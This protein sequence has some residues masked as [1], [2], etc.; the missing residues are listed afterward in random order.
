[1]TLEP[2]IAT[3]GRK[4][5]TK[6]AQ[7]GSSTTTTAT[8]RKAAPATNEE[9]PAPELK[10]NLLN[11]VLRN[12]SDLGFDAMMLNGFGTPPPHGGNLTPITMN[13]LMPSGASQGDFSEVELNGFQSDLTQVDE[14]DYADAQYSIWKQVT[15]QARA[16][17]AGDRN[18]LFI[19]NRL[20][21]EETAI[22][23]N[24]AGMR[25]FTRLQKKYLKPDDSEDITESQDE[26]RSTLVGETLAQ[27]VEAAEDDYILPDYY[28]PV[29]TVPEINKRLKWEL[30]DEGQVISHAEECLRLVPE[31]HF[32]AP[33]SV[34]GKRLATN[35]KQMQETRKICAKIAVVKQMQMQTQVYQN[36]FQKYEPA[37]LYELDIGATVV[38][39]DG[40]IMSPEVCRAAFQRSI[41]KI[42]YNAGFED[43]QPAALDTITDLVGEFFQKLTTDFVAY[44]SMPKLPTSKPHASTGDATSL[45]RFT[46]EESLIHT[47]EQNSI[48]IESLD[49]YVKDDVDR[50]SAKLSVVHERMKSHLADLL[51]STTPLISKYILTHNS[52]LHLMQVLEQMA[53]VLSTMAVNSLLVET[54]LSISTKI[55]LAS[56]NLVWI[57]NLDWLL[58]TY[59]FTFFKIVCTV[60]IKAKTP[61]MLFLSLYTTQL[62]TFN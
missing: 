50:L 3:R 21:P 5:P 52:D 40:P 48:E 45:P 11:Q 28:D 61:R 30:D 8:S 10:A 31:G 7:K 29:S 19:N 1:M 9:T 55:S 6:G 18:R 33:P 26:G 25:R 46:L 22:L 58:S 16:T 47:L 15:K 14:P 36:Q 60:H 42:C 43:F 23:R 32:T 17:A 2:I 13:G 39:D 34:L 35:M 41:G 59:P 12:G 51:V 37:P 56:E 4:A 54:L 57:E 38:S 24:K 27:G 62:L 49:A 44:A 20:N 53:L